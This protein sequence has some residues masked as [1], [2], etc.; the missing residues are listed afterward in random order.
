M[1][2]AEEPGLEGLLKQVIMDN[3]DEEV[4]GVLVIV[5]KGSEGQVY[6]HNVKH[7]IIESIGAL[8]GPQN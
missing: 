4:V 2:E 8:L 6:S 3:R 1:P 5:F 7:E